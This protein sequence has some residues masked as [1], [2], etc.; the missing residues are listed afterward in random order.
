MSPL[1]LGCERR[2]EFGGGGGL[3]EESGAPRWPVKPEMHL[4]FKQR[5]GT[6]SG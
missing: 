5:C 2:R 3:G 6:D 1:D 4:A